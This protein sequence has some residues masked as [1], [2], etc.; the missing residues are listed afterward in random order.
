MNQRIAVAIEELPGNIYVVAENFSRCSKFVVCEINSK[1]IVVQK[2][3]YFNPLNG[4][5]KSQSQ[6]PGYINQFDVDYIIAGVMDKKT[7]S[8]FHQF[9]INV[10]TAPKL[11]FKDALEQFLFGKLNRYVEKIEEDN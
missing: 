6:L 3:T 8:N 11:Q 7:L 1:K 9:R 4:H 5:Q 10:I 2:E